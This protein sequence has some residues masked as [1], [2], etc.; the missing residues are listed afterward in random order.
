ME[1]E[2][3]HILTTRHTIE[4]RWYCVDKERCKE[5]D[6]MIA[7][8]THHFNSLS[9]NVADKYIT[10][11]E[12]LQREAKLSV[13]LKDLKAERAQL[14]RRGKKEVEETIDETTGQIVATSRKVV[15]PRKVEE[16]PF[17]AEASLDGKALVQIRH[18]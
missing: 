6:E 4:T 11:L 12:C 13:I 7:S 14:W 18:V 9:A 10:G 8:A 16:G 15:P 17:I 3:I 1:N 5:L 2:P